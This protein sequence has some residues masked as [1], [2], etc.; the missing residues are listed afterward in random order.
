MKSLFLFFLF[1]FIQNAY[2]VSFEEA[3]NNLTTLESYIKEY[4]KTKGA[5]YSVIHLITTYI[6]EG[7]Y[8][9]TEW[10]IAGGSIPSDLSSYI[11][12]KDKEKGTNV[13]AIKKYNYIEL[14][15]NE[16][17]DFVHFFAV[18]NGIEFG[19]SYTGVYSSLVGWGGDMA[20]MLQDIK[21][22]TGTLDELIKIVLTQYLGIK[23]Q[24][25]PE[26]LL[27]DLDAPVILSKINDDNTF[28]SV[29][30]QYY[31]SDEYKNR[32]TEFLKLTFPNVTKNSLREQIL[33]RYS[34]DNLINVLECKY[35]VREKGL[36]GCYLPGNIM[37]Q[38][39]N[40]QMAVAYAFADYLNAHS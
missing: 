8:S 34:K 32:V 16:I 28:S 15:S 13:A 3:L 2:S 29:I 38:Y 5:S 31:E 17:L 9:T 40:H 19:D 21:G 11:E 12:E 4:K 35:G 6:R 10:S 24:F 23:G 37:S 20:Q 26:D 25:G 27:S 33:L 14:P 22:E 7:K 30:K 39:K 1:L 36:I 18:M